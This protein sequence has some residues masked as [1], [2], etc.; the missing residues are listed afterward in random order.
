MSSSNSGGDVD[1]SVVA[2]EMGL[3]ILMLLTWS[4]LLGQ[5]RVC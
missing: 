3:T 1:L 5:V 2:L 4:M